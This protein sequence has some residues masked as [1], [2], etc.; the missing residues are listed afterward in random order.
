[1]EIFL[2]MVV[3]KRCRLLLLNYEIQ[4]IST[5]CIDL[6]RVSKNFSVLRLQVQVQTIGDLC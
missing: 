4:C 3:L 2:T 5:R 1:M 6:E